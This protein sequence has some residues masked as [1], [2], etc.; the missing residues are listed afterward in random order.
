M[1]PQ[2]EGIKIKISANY[3]PLPPGEG[4]G[5]RVKIVN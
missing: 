2:G 3:A 4:L 1:N 5:V